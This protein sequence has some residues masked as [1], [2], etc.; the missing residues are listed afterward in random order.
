MLLGEGFK[1][2]EVTFTS[3]LAACS[4]AGLVDE[5]CAYL[6]SM[7]I[8]YGIKPNTYHRLCVIDLLAR[9]GK[10]LEAESMVQSLESGAIIAWR[11]LLTA[12]R[13]Y[14]NVELGR[15]CFGHVVMLDPDNASG[16]TLMSR[17]YSDAGMLEE[18]NNIE[19][20]RGKC[21]PRINEVEAVL[22]RLR[23]QMKGVT[24]I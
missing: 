18:A 4:N 16:Y 1:P 20:L 19:K 22:K 10:L 15:Y 17:I 5:G 14:G 6:R 13:T 21:Q 24:Y 7:T 11:S 2:N 23:K 12:C 8:D 9:A 3:V